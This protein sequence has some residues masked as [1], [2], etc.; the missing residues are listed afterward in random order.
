MNLLEGIV[1]SGHKCIVATG[2]EKGSFWSIT[3]C[4]L[5]GENLFSNC[6]WLS[7]C[8]KKKKVGRDPSPYCGNTCVRPPEAVLCVLSGEFAVPFAAFR[9]GQMQ[10]WPRP[11]SRPHY[12]TSSADW[13]QMC[14]C[15]FSCVHSFALNYTSPGWCHPSKHSIL[16]Q[17]PV[18][19]LL[20]IPV[21]YNWF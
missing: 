20:L 2:A 17:L 14:L 4:A 15:V 6:Q 5:F 12:C 13:E 11:F 1:I 9:L 8:Y 3:T 18:C 19:I 16:E 7:V 21:R 10:G